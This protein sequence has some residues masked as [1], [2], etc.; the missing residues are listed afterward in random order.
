MTG[1][2]I[3]S[4]KQEGQRLDVAL[5]SFFPAL[6][7][8][9]VRRAW[10]VYLVEL[11]HK[12]ARKGM[13]VKAGDEV[14]ITAIP[15][16]RELPELAELAELP[17]LPEQGE[18]AEALQNHKNFKRDGELNTPDRPNSTV[19]PD[20]TGSPDSPDNKGN[21]GKT[22]NTGSMNNMS[23]LSAKKQALP[24]NPWKKD[25]SPLCAAEKGKHEAAPQTF[26]KPD[27]STLRI[28]HRE[29]GIIAIFKPA[30]LHSAHV[31]GGGL[32]LEQLLPELC[33]KENIDPAGVALFNR[34]DCLTSGIVLA[35][36]NATAQRASLQ[37]EK[38][39][40]AEKRYLAIVRGHILGEFWIKNSL[41]TDSRR[42]T[43]VLPQANPDPLRHTLVRPIHLFSNLS[44]FAP[45]Q[46]FAPEQNHLNAELSGRLN[47]P[48]ANQKACLLE[49][50]IFQ[51]ARHQ[52]RA[53]LASV[54]YPI[55][56]DPLYDPDYE[57]A[58]Q[59]LY[60]HHFAISLPGFLCVA[61]PPWPINCLGASNNE[62]ENI[63]KGIFP[64]MYSFI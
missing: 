44:A 1:T 25:L 50:T 11:N 12:H 40:K 61:P 23:K 26:P 14:T 38:Q 34:L 9:E 32:S 2:Y 43:K 46:H 62:L 48:S 59:G 53:H 10:G 63:L 45:E 37:A 42:K 29:N 16:Q 8:R 57:E 21:K 47:L 24:E 22:G 54:G 60:L 5:S 52:I 13:F 41:D 6:S 18:Q 19:S 36:E 30:G 56:G 3:I 39:E 31:Q 17:E 35:T 55:L 33:A 15:E 58:W 20:N 64:G 51:G 49:V 28:L 7:L 27:L 4:N